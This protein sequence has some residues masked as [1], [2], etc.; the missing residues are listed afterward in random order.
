[1]LSSRTYNL[2]IWSKSHYAVIKGLFLCIVFAEDEDEVVVA[3]DVCWEGVE[4]LGGGGIFI[5]E[6][7]LSGGGGVVENV[8]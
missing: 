8:K 2:E 3:G 7:F 1:M 5:F 6:D 4:G